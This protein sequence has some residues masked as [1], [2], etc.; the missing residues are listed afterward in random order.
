MWCKQNAFFEND[1]KVNYISEWIPFVVLMFCTKI[2]KDNE[3][4]LI[5][6]QRWKWLLNERAYY[7]QNINNDILSFII[8]T[9][10]LIVQ[11]KFIYPFI[12]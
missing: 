9:D 3:N 4:K 6:H 8:F 10:K 7:D 5:L 2:A 1:C 12:I 11:L